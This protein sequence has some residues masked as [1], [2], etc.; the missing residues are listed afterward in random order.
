MML[1]RRAPSRE[2]ICFA[3]LPVWTPDGKVW[4]EWVHYRWIDAGFGGY[5]Y[6]RWIPEKRYNEGERR[7]FSEHKPRGT[8]SEPCGRLEC[9]YPDCICTDDDLKKLKRARAHPA[10]KDYC[11]YRMSCKDPHCDCLDAETSHA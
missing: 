4:L 2:G 9:G 7:R 6:A 1:L 5:E 10:T 8:I 3:W 11:R